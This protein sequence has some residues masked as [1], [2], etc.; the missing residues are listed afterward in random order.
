MSV[1]YRVGEPLIQF[2]GNRAFVKYEKTEEEVHKKGCKPAYLSSLIYSYAREHMTNTILQYN[3]IYQDTD[4]ALVSEE[5]Y[6]S[7]V[8]DMP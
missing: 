2:S 7:F 5:D 1:K 3:P 4:S 8:Q 6:L